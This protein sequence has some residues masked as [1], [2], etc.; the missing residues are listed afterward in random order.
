ILAALT[1]RAR[2]RNADPAARAW[3]AWC[4]K[5]ARA[6]LPRG[7]SE[8]PADYAARVARARPDLAAAR[9]AVAR[10]DIPLRHAPAAAPESL[11]QLLQQVKA[12]PARRHLSGAPVAGG[13]AARR[14]L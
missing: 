7:A 6:G 13:H 11:P 8:G 9:A 3:A 4:R 14:C 5:L 10:L 12:F 2:G 1:L